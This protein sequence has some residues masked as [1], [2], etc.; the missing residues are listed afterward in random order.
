MAQGMRHGMLE[1]SPKMLGN[2]LENDGAAWMDAK[3]ILPILSL[4]DWRDIFFTPKNEIDQVELNH[5]RICET[6]SRFRLTTRNL[7][8]NLGDIVVERPADIIK[9]AENEGLFEVESDSDDISCVLYCKG[10]RLLDLELV[11]EQ[12][13]LVV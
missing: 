6:K 4:R 5:S 8:G 11:L 3:W 7:S 2:E 10:A 13:L 12:E 9:I 1:T